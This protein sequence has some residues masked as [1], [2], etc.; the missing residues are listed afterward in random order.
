MKLA[1]LNC[2]RDFVSHLLLI[3]AIRSFTKDSELH[4]S[5][6]LL[7][8]F[9][10]SHSL[11]S[12]YVVEL[13]QKGLLM[14]DISNVSLP[15]PGGGGSSSIKLSIPYES[16]QIY[17]TFDR[18]VVRAN[19]I[20]SPIM[21]NCI[22]QLIQE[23]TISE[24]IEYASIY[25]A[26]L[27]IRF[28]NIGID[29][30]KLLLIAH[31]CQL[32]QAFMLAWRTVKTF[33]EEC[34]GQELEFSEFSDRAYRFFL[35]YRKQDLPIR[36]YAR[37]MQLKITQIQYLIYSDLLQLSE[38]GTEIVDLLNRLNLSEQLRLLT[39]NRHL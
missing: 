25:A 23:I 4:L 21:I 37:P 14:A 13:V 27:G 8:R 12:K 28:I 38:N 20:E 1:D 31:E 15:L 36:S 6:F 32:S 16:K 19:M 10:P 18:S 17:D 39:V 34:P 11:C 35:E 22:A 30:P 24:L 33:S 2:P 7:R 26:K 3:A 9:T 29:Q 5:Q